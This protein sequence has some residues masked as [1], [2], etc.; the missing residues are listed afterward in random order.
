MR[1]K[2]EKEVFD[3]LHLENINFQYEP[4]LRIKEH[5]F[6]PD[7]LLGNVIIECTFWNNST[8]ERLDYLKTKIK[9]Y[10]A[11]SY[12]V[13]FFIPKN[14]RKFYKEIDS[15][16]VSGFVQLYNRIAPP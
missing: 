7:F 9:S 10:E 8:K 4:C 15:F 3:F 6:F 12:H 14:C 1:N 11:A 5:V 2:L 16:V 13:V